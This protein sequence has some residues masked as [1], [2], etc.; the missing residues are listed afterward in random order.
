[1]EKQKTRRPN[2]LPEYDYAQP[3]AYFVTICTK[4]R[5][6]LL[7]RIS[8]GATCGRPDSVVLTHA[9][10]IVERELNRIGEIYENV[11]VDSYAIMPNHVHVILHIREGGGRPQVAPTV[12]R[13]VQQ[14]KGTVTK[15]LGQAI[16]QKGFYDHVIRDEQDY[17]IKRK[18]IKEN[19]LKWA[20]DEYYMDR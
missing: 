11:A 20:L 3:G 13:V 14:M 15:K 16:W 4:D 18:Y 5:Q 6:C 10:E 12:S 19:P 1:M 17:L 8:V 7:S 2:R 9:G